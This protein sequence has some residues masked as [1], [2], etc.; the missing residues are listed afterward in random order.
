M[1]IPRRARDVTGDR[2]TRTHVNLQRVM[3]GVEWREAI[4]AQIK[5]RTRHHRRQYHRPGRPPRP[6]EPGPGVEARTSR[7]KRRTAIGPTAGSLDL[8]L[9]RWSGSPPPGRTREVDA[10]GKRAGR[11]EHPPR[12]PARCERERGS[13]A[14]RRAGSRRG[15]SQA[16]AGGRKAE[17]MADWVCSALTTAGRDV[18]VSRCDK[19]GFFFSVITAHRPPGVPCLA[20]T[21]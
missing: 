11:S 20:Y 2:R 16:R 13:P 5:N 6:R 4:G 14:P 15:G 8:L 10:G 19:V 9:A 12:S 1:L 7:R 3:E 21:T 17:A 18:R